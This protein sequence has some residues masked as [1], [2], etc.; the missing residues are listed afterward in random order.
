MLLG[1]PTK[2]KTKLGWEPKVDLKQ[3]AKM[4]VDNDHKLACEER[5]LA[6][7]REANRQ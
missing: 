4:M 6:E 3:L 5:V 7:H 1:D 2:A